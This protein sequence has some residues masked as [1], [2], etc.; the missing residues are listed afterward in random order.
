MSKRARCPQ[1][2]R[3]LAACFCHTISLIDNELPVIILQHTSEVKHAKGTAKIVELSL[4]NIDVFVGEDFTDNDE[5]LTKLAAKKSLLLYPQEDAILPQQLAQQ[6]FENH[7]LKLS[8][9][10]LVVIDGSWKK[11]FKTLQLNPFLSD[12]PAIGIDA[13]NESDYRIRKSSR[14]DSLSTLEAIHAVLT[15]VEGDKFEGLLTSF[16]A[17]VDFQIQ[18]MPKDVQERY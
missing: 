6:I 9:Y 17:M 10:Q 11:A 8:D 13:V 12:L 7:A 1:C 15:V 4:N 3:A 5:L 18:S 2:N 16:K 14:A